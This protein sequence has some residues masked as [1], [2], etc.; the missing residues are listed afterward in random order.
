MKTPWGL[1]CENSDKFMRYSAVVLTQSSAPNWVDQLFGIAVASAHT[2]SSD[3]W[4]LP[5]G[6]GTP[7]QLT[8]IATLGLCGN[9][10]PDGKHIASYSGNGIFIMNPDGTLLTILVNDNG[11]LAGTLASVPCACGCCRKSVK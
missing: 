9:L 8:H 2:V 4:S 10:S 1:Y 5:I 7:T 11:S 6:G 3:W